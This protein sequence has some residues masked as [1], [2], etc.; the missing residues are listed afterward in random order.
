MHTKEKALTTFISQIYQPE[1]CGQSDC[2][3]QVYVK[4]NI[5]LTKI[6]Q[7]PVHHPNKTWRNTMMRQ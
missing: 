4:N 5:L 3:I 6:T 1:L 7:L 2:S